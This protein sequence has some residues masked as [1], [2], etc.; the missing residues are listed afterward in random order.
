M[1]LAHL[2]WIP[3]AIA[4]PVAAAVRTPTKPKPLPGLPYPPEARKKNVEGNVVLTGEIT[5]E[6]KVTGLRVLASSSP[7]LEKAALTYVSRFSYYGGATENGKPISICLN[8]VV[9]FV[10][11]RTR[12]NDPVSFPSP[13]IGN[14]ALYP[15]PK[16]GN[17]NPADEGFPVELEDK[18]LQ[19]VLDLDVPGTFSP[20]IY[21]VDVIDVGPAGKTTLLLQKAVKSDKQNKTASAPFF[22]TIAAGDRS[23]KGLHTVRVTVDGIIAGGGQYRVGS[24]KS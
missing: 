6:G 1:K 13:I 5:P 9:H 4:L 17:A 23:E 19:G 7:L 20:R 12:P 11:D 14:L 10:K 2:L 8:T 15:V 21:T 3:F 22:R 24:K 16:K 18:G